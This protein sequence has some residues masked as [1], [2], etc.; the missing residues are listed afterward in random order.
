MIVHGFRSARHTEAKITSGLPGWN[1][2]STAPVESFTNSTFSQRFPPSVVRKTPRSAFGLNGFPIAATKATSGFV[3]TALAGR[4]QR[5][6]NDATR[7]LLHEIFHYNGMLNQA[8]ARMSLA[9]SAAAI[10]VW[11]LALWKTRALGR[12]VALLGVT[13]AAATLAGLA[14]GSGHVGV[15]GI[16]L[17]AGGQGAWTVWVGVAL[18]RSGSGAAAAQPTP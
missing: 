14:L 6:E 10:L 9:A 4:Y 16:L 5:A 7:Q 12:G 2:T 17:Y 18:L 1:S 15:H 11:S 13:V 8:F 3:G